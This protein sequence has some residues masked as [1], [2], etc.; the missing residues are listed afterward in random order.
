MFGFVERGENV[1][2][3]TVI[4]K[5][6]LALDCSPADLLADFTPAALR[7]LKLI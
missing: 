1:P 5:M 7:R 2:T 3:L 4:L 6:A